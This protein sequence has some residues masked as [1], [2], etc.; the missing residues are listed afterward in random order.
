MNAALCEASLAQDEDEVPIGAV[1]VKDG[2]IIS[3]AH[4][5]R[6]SLK[7][8]TAHAEILAIREACKAVGAWRLTGC[9]MYVTIE[10]C[11][12]CAGAIVLS[13]MDRLIFG[14]PDPKAGACGSVM[15]IVR[16]PL[17]NHRVEVTGGVLKDKCR[18]I[19]K[20]Y[21]KNKRA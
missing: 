5:M 2:I 4:N 8:S 9:E 14:A 15:D 1:I 6:E 17:L 16:N 7:D 19:I 12:M 10:P 3:S 20:R 13:R 18:D 11:A 21:F